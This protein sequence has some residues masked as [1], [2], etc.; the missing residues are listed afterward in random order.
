MAPTYK[1]PN[2]LARWARDI[3]DSELYELSGGMDEIVLAT[4]GEQV[5]MKEKDFVRVRMVGN[6]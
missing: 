4:I 2:I 3:P 1:R 6:L 5:L